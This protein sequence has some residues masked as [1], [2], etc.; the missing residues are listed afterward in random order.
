[1]E[2]DS[3]RMMLCGGISKSIEYR[4]QEFKAYDELRLL[5]AK[6]ALNRKIE[7]ERSEC[8]PMDFNQAQTWGSPEQWDWNTNTQDDQLRNQQKLPQPTTPP[9]DVICMY[10][11]GKGKG[12]RN[13]KGGK[14]TSNSSNPAQYYIMIAMTATKRGSKGFSNAGNLCSQRKGGKV[15]GK[16]G[17]KDCYNCGR[18]GHA[19]NCPNPKVETRACIRCGKSGHLARECRAAPPA[20]A[21]EEEE[22]QEASWGA[23]RTEELQDVDAAAT[24]KGMNEKKETVLNRAVAN[25]T[26]RKKI[27]GGH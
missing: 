8:D 14:G 11:K 27:Q 13:S 22:G 15:G 6:W 7:H 20:R 24:G 9:T 26:W 17:G 16:T 21:V 18:S 12:D 19:R 2:E 3:D 5:V 23:L 1:M 10:S 4:E 25:P